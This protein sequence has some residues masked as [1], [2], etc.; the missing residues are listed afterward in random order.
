MFE[1]DHE[2]QR[3]ITRFSA[4]I[5][6]ARKAKEAQA[7]RPPPRRETPRSSIGESAELRSVKE[8]IRREKQDILALEAMLS[9]LE[10][11]GPGSGSPQEAQSTAPKEA[12]AREPSEAPAASPVREPSS[13]S[14][15]RASLARQ[16]TTPGRHM[17][18]RSVAGTPR[19][20]S[21][22][23]VRQTL[24]ATPRRPLSKS[25]GSP[26]VT[27]QTPERSLLRT[28]MRT[29]TTPA[30]RGATPGR[31]AATPGAAL[32]PE[33]PASDT[34]PRHATP[35]RNH[36]GTPSKASP[37]LHLVPL[38]V[39]P[40]ATPERERIAERIWAVFGENLRYVAPGC[41][42]APFA[43]T[44]ALLSALES[45]GRTPA[46]HVAGDALHPM[47]P[48]RV[49][50]VIMAHVLLL[51]CRSPAPHALPL[52]AIKSY[53]DKWWTQCGRA[54]MQA[55]AAAPATL[56]EPLK[57]LGLDLSDIHQPCENLARTAV[58]GLMAKKL[59]RIRHAGGTATVHFA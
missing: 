45:C 17:L 59:L 39:V 5:E 53:T 46:E 58:Y 44:F 34:T 50:T 21:L 22:A 1:R 10:V 32:S 20:P 52:L 54:E 25:L 14:S 2:V 19:A 40:E 55:A 11:R 4:T 42:G 23:T 31:S 41:S 36:S 56:T 3:A 30:R 48:L 57:S 28:S 18:S 9:E 47:S 13:R 26:K 27:P 37:R 7:R 33:T 16:S 51:L 29:T 24:E 8:E 49:G 35:K 38:G 12:P 43:T 6:N 15:L